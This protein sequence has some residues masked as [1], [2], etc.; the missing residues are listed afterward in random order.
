MTSLSSEFTDM[1]PVRRYS[2]YVDF[3]TSPFEVSTLLDGQAFPFYEIQEIV[4]YD[5]LGTPI[6]SNTTDP[7]L[8]LPFIDFQCLMNMGYNFSTCGSNFDFMAE[9][10]NGSMVLENG[11]GFTAEQYTDFYS[12][13][14][15][16]GCGG[17]DLVFNVTLGVSPVREDARDCTNLNVECQ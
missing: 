6:V 17:R 13:D 2:G 12:N 7:I 10:A 4:S 14:F 11:Y 5:T 8:H 9:T 3:S 16:E 1:Y 15:G